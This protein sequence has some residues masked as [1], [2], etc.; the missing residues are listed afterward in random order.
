MT[1]HADT[2]LGETLSAAMNTAPDRGAKEPRGCRWITGDVRSGDWSYCQP[3]TNGGPYC[4]DHAAKA[5]KV[6]TSGR[7]R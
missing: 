1:D 2:R 5:G 3:P 4:P 6:Y 7:A